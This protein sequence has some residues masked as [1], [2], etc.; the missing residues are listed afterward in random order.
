[1]YKIK[2]Y[3]RKI[4]A[5]IKYIK[6]NAVHEFVKSEGYEFR[7]NICEEDVN[8][9]ADI[10]EKHGIN[11]LIERSAYDIYGNYLDNFQA[12]Y[13][14]AKTGTSKGFEE[15]ISR[16]YDTKLNKNNL[17][18]EYILWVYQL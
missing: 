5:I 8:A 9:Y 12:F 6:A 15:D 17:K 16:Y 1:M 14:G 11:Y 18:G 13:V 10:S 2:Y 3:I 4:V 7:T